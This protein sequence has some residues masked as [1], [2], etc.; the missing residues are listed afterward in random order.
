[1]REAGNTEQRYSVTF[2]DGVNST[3]QPS[4]SKRTEL[5]HSENARSPQIGVLE[6]RNGY[7]PTGTTSSGGRFYASE[8]HGLT[9][10]PTQ[11][12]S[13]QGV[14]RVSSAPADQDTFSVNAYE[15]IY[16][17]EPVFNISFLDPNFSVT[18]STTDFSVFVSDTVTVTEPSFLVTSDLVTVFIGNSVSAADIFY[19]SSSSSWVKMTDVDA[20]NMIGGQFDFTIANRD[21]V[22]VNQHNKNVMV[23]K[24]GVTVITSQDSGS[25]Y[26]S[27]PASKVCYYKN[28]IHLADFTRG[29]VRY[30][31]T[32]LRSSYPL[33]IIA[34]VDGDHISASTE[35]SVTD[36]KYFY[37]A[38]GVNLYDVYRGGT[39]IETL[40]V[41][42]VNE[43]TITV[44][45]IA[46]ALSSADEIWIA[47]TYEGEKQF[48]WVNNPTSTGRDVKQYDTFKLSGGDEDPITL[49][50]TIGDVIMIGNRNSLAAWDDYTLQ[51]ID[52]NIGCSSKNG[53]TKLLGTLYF[54]HDTGI[55]A[56]TGGLPTLISRKVE[57][58]IKGATKEGLENAA[59]GYKGLSVLFA[60]GDSTIYKEDGSIE[61]VL[62]D[63]CLE[64][65]VADQNWYVHTNMP[66]SEFT[67]Y[68]SGDGVEHSLATSTTGSK[69]VM[70][71]LS[72]NTDD[73]DEIFFRVDTQE[74]QL[75]KEFETFSNPLAVVTEIYRGTQM[76]CF[77]SCDKDDFYELDGTIKKGVSI[78]KVNS[79][80]TSQ[81]KPVLCRKIKLSYRDSSK[82]LCRINQ[83]A[84][85]YIPTTMDEPSE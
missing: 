53:S 62:H 18:S 45:S 79:R 27:P 14:F 5:S 63:V 21:L 3:V 28:R 55:F 82:Q 56:T 72:G 42:T 15:Q 34:L 76:R 30:P 36:T 37:A 9:R 71:I 70:D 50:D 67:N 75:L 40:T 11:N 17:Q 51:N 7:S 39:K 24:D 4:L 80:D 84:I 54:I 85:V 64:Y 57:R 1:M 78:V 81:K 61:K 35:I 13:Q 69:S 6:K 83:F 46:N 10:F 32:I 60:I 49:F 23:K 66:M 31:T 65:S 16:I 8:N 59:A 26:N 52:L 29:S 77:V 43:T 74:I 12:S 48:R 33:G 73:G 68:M 2:F 20:Q 19:L 41:T 22:L 58:Y 38:S 25:L 44:N 47:G